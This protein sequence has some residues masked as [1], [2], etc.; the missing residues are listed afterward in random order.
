MSYQWQDCTGSVCSAIAKAASVPTYTVA[1]TD[2]GHTIVVKVTATNKFG[3]VSASSKPTAMVTA[4]ATAPPSAPTIASTS[5]QQTSI[6]MT[7][8]D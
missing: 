1:S 2:V 8:S 7:W 5:A 6:T 3:G 4:P